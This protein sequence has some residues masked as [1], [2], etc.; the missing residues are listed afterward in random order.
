MILDEL[1]FGLKK[2]LPM[3]LQTEAAECGLACLAMVANFHGYSVDLPT[4]RQK[5]KISSK[6]TRLRQIVHFANSLELIARPLKLELSGLNQLITPCILHWDL[7]HF[8]V[9]KSVKRRHVIIHDPAYGIRNLS[10]EQLSRHFTGIALELSPGPKFEKKDQ[11]QQIRLGMLIGKIV[12]F[13]RAIIQIMSLSIVLQLI[14]S[15][16]PF[17][18]QWVLDGIVIQSDRDLLAVL[19]IGFV[20]LIFIQMSISA[21]RS[22][23]ILYF[24]TQVSIQWA[25]GV[26]EKLLHLPISYFERRHLGDIVSR[27]NAIEGIRQTITV[28][29]LNVILD[30][31]LAIFSLSIMIVYSWKLAQ[32]TII[33]LTIYILFRFISYD[34]FKLAN[35]EQIV[36]N[37]KQQS[38]FL[39]SIRGIQ[40]IKLFNKENERRTQWL[41]LLVGATNRNITTQRLSTIYQTINGLVFGIEGVIVTYLGAILIIDNKFSIGMMFAYSSYK[42]QFSGRISSLVDIFFQLKMLSIQKERLADIVLTPPELQGKDLALTPHL[43]MAIEVRNISFRYSS[44]EPWIFRNISFRIS[45]GESVAIVGPS[46]CGKTTLLKVMLGLLIPEEGEILIGNIP[47]NNFSLSSWRDTIGSVMQEDQLFTGS[48][49]NNISFYASDVDFKKLEEVTMLAAI[50]DDIIRM[51]MGYDTLVGDMGTTISGGQKQ[52]ILLARALYKNPRVL[53]LDEATSHLDVDRERIV[54]RSIND[55]SITRIFIAHR[56]ETIKMAERVITLDLDEKNLSEKGVKLAT[57]H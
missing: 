38:H 17:F 12:G 40:S 51:P 16:A 8:V 31:V 50:H 33:S 5:F 35:E 52:R 57:Q 47:F 43:K 27:F 55:L 29:A 20:F 49:A 22:W 14:S 10:F 56:P 19:T 26:F 54:N 6:G 32:V 28:T 45:E 1:N 30:G 25:A 37:A 18:Q 11:R 2:R 53:F 13:R 41:N 46:G 42:L 48:I 15:L 7:N 36:L 24:S 4:L 34:S 9:L 23:L 44:S 21:I 3:L 39:E